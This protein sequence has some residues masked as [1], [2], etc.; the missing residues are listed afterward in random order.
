MDGLDGIYLRSLV[1]KEHRQSDAKNFPTGVASEL[2]QERL[3]HIL[4]YEP[5]DG[6]G[7][8]AKNGVTTALMNVHPSIHISVIF[9]IPLP[10]S[11]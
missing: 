5:W 2:S 1:L 7:C 9:I 10:Y 11:R 8:T 4:S 3:V 6:M